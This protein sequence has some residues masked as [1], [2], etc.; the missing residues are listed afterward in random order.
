MQNSKIKIYDV[1]IIGTGPAGLWAAKI[2]AK[3]K[4]KTLIIEK[5]AII[6]PKICA[7]GLT[8]KD[9]VNG[10]PKE[11]LECQFN[12]VCI[13]SP[14]QCTKIKSDYFLIGTVN[15]KDLGE[16]MKK[17]IENSNVKIICDQVLDVDLRKNILE[18]KS[19]KLIHYKYLI[20]A[21]GSNSIVRQKLGLSQN[22]FY[23]AYQYKIKKIFANLEIILDINRFGPWYIWIF[24]HYDHT[25]IGTGCDPNVFSAKTNRREFEKW[26]KENKIDVSDAEF[27]AWKINYDYQGFQF[28]NV[29]LVGDAGGFTSGLT[30]EGIYAAMISGQE[31]ARKIINPSYNL[32]KLNLFLKNKDKHEKIVKEI[33]NNSIA[34]KIKMELVLFLAKFKFINKLLIKLTV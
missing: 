19:G 22:K 20:G 2:L 28:N 27:Q 10:I 17:Q 3:S 5:N 18:L 11:I 26:L 8:F 25:L 30:G 1:V 29:F 7:G 4:L 13:K 32:K 12:E 23:V 31:A 6:G 16:W 9:I 15:R 14:I 21:D 34:T 33:Q 24:P